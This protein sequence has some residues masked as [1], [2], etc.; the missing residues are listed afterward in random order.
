VTNAFP[1]TGKL[2]AVKVVNPATVTLKVPYA[3]NVICL[4]ANA[5]VSQD[6]GVDNVTN[7]WPGSSGTRKLNVESVSVTLEVQDLCSVT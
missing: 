4:M 3:S 1:I 5:I 2:P 6:L 7:A